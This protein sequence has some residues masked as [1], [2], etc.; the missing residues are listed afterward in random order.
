MKL[1]AS[2]AFGANQIASSELFSALLRGAVVSDRKT[3]LRR[4]SRRAQRN[5][6]TG[7]VASRS[8]AHSVCND[9]TENVDSIFE[10][11]PFDQDDEQLF[12]RT[13]RSLVAAPG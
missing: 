1:L 13:C 2:F 4:R 11:V 7:E 9:V 6:I 8:S 12:D 3:P 10:T 5:P